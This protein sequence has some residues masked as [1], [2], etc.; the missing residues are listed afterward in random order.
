MRI[1][2]L[3]DKKS[4]E[5]CCLC[6]ARLV[7]NFQ[8]NERIL[9]EI[10]A[11]GLL[12][13]VQQLVSDSGSSVRDKQETVSFLCCVQNL[14]SNLSSTITFQ[15]SLSSVFQLILVS[16]GNLA[17]LLLFC[18]VEVRQIGVKKNPRFWW[19]WTDERQRVLSM[20]SA[21]NSSKN[22]LL[23]RPHPH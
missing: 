2:L 23:L 14:N 9:K 12:S 17:V 7:D 18:L 22:S 3:Q 6:F 1:F 20:R 5:S 8:T 16:N 11:H 13:S 21:P 19:H 4:V 15:L 10:A